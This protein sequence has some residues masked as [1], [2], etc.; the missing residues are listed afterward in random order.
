MSRVAHRTIARPGVAAPVPRGTEPATRTMPERASIASDVA[1]APTV[2]KIQARKGSRPAYARMEEGEGWDTTITPELASFISAQTSVFLGT[3]NAAGQPYVQHRGGPAGFLR[4][5]D[6]H[7]LAFADFRGNR[8]YITQGNL[9]ENPKAYLFLIDYSTRQRIKIWGT[10]RVVEDDPA[11][12]A[13]LMPPN[14]EARGEQ[15]IVFTVGAWNANCPRHIPQRFDAADVTAA[16]EARDRRIAELE[17]EIARLN[18]KE[19]RLTSG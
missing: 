10:A 12:V 14:Y 2:K 6:A 16:V 1:F 4:V 15:A 8:Q 9:A 13:R 5:H 3:A 18:T 11:R 17:A 7:T 19:T